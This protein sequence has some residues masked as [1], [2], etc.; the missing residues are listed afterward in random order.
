MDGEDENDYTHRCCC[1]YYFPC[2]SRD[3]REDANEYA[4][5]LT[6]QIHLPLPLLVLLLLFSERE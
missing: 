5:F 3:L 4:Q 2:E 1:C 6:V